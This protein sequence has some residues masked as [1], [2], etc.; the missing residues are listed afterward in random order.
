MIAAFEDDYLEG[1][2]MVLELLTET[3]L[4]LLNT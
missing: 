4:N 1:V 2:E 3:L